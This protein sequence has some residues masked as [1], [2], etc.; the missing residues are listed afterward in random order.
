MAFYSQFLT[1]GNVLACG[2]NYGTTSYLDSRS[3]REFS[4]NHCVLHQGLTII[5]V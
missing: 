5:Q 3:W 4:M 1:T 2:I